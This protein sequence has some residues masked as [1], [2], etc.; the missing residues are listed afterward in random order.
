MKLGS[1]V[2]ARRTLAGVSA[3]LL[4]AT[5]GA[6]ACSNS[7]EDGGGAA[8]SP[9]TSLPGNAA[10]GSPVKIGFIST[11]GGTITVCPGK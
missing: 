4:A 11:E 1:M 9:T 10:T 5:L 7:D 3:V 6:T 8:T 2:R